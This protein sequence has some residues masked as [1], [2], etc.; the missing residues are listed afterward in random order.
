MIRFLGDYDPTTRRMLE[1]ILANEEKHAEEL[2]HLLT[3]L[4]GRPASAPTAPRG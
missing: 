2:V 1:G 3:S 4:D